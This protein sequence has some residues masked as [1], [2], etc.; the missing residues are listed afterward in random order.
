[1]AMPP[2]RDTLDTMSY[3][4][5]KETAVTLFA[6]KPPVFNEVEQTLTVKGKSYAG[7]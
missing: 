3:W 4:P 6:Q 1:M 2:Y 7:K 5:E